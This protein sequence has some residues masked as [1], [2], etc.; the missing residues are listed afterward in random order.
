MLT[1]QEIKLL[2]KWEFKELKEQVLYEK[3]FLGKMRIVVSKI[4]R[5]YVAVT[6]TTI[7]VEKN[8]ENYL[9]ELN[10]ATKQTIKFVREWNK[11]QEKRKQLN[12]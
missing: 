7:Q 12:E 1:K 2:K 4:K 3:V 6:S 9:L 10:E 5:R 8:L 11:V